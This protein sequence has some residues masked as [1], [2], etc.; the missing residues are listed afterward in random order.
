MGE[1]LKKLVFIAQVIDMDDA[2]NQTLLSQIR[3]TR[4]LNRKSIVLVQSDLN[5]QDVSLNLTP[6]MELE[7]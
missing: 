1:R 6:V 7:T 2:S 5:M 3:F 4:D